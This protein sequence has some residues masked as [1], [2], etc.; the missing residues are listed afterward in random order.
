M[1]FD[2]VRKLARELGTVEESPAG[3]TPWLKVHGKLMAWT[4]IH[5]SVEPGSLAVRINIDQRDELIA[6]A[7]D[8]YYLTDHYENYP[9][10]LVRLSHIQPAALKD[11]LRMAMSFVTAKRRSVRR[12]R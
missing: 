3:E 2:L 4:P 7:P 1:D 6:E 10:V 9:P 5:K 12:L 11:L 8:I